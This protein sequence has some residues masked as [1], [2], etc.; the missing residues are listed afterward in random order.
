MGLFDLG[1]CFIEGMH[2]W[3]VMIDQSNPFGPH[4]LCLPPACAPKGGPVFWPSLLELFYVITHILTS[5]IYASLSISNLFPT[6]RARAFRRST[7]LLIYQQQFYITLKMFEESNFS[8]DK[9]S[10]Y[11]KKSSNIK[12]LL[13]YTYPKRFKV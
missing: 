3:H 8:E 6:D 10:S 4:L 2:D 13:L 11:Q 9:K 12:D 5:A 7:E 1:C